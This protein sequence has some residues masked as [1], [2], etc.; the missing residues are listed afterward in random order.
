[1]TAAPAAVNLLIFTMEHDLAAKVA[2][3]N[4]M[5]PFLSY[6]IPE[7]MRGL[8]REGS[9]VRVP[10]RGGTAE[11]VVMAVGPAD[12]SK[13][14]LRH[15]A[16]LVQPQ[17][18]L[19]PDLLKLAVWM[20]DYYCAGLQSV[21][22]SMIPAAVRCGKGSMRLKE[23]SIARRLGED[24]MQRLE[25]R[26]P[27]QARLYG[28][29]LQN[30]GPMLR[31]ALLKMAGAAD[32]AAAA[33]IEK[34]VFAEAERTVERVSYE[35][36][37]GS[38]ERVASSPHELNSEQ[39]AA[40]GGILSAIGSKKFAAH[41]LY[42]VTG[43][44]KT[45]VYMQAMQRV[46]QDGGSCI[47]L[48][49]EISLTPQTVGR[50]RSRLGGLGTELVV[51]HSGLSDGQRLDAWRALAEG[52]A[53][54]VVGAR[55]CVFAPIENPDLIIV[56]EEHDGA[57]KQDKTPRYNG[58]DV[59]VYRAHLA[60]STCVLGSATPSLETLYNVRQKKYGMSRIASR[61]DGASLPKVV[62]ADMRHEKPGAMISN[63]LAS[64]LMEKMDRGE[65]AMLFL[66]RRGY[67]KVYEC[68]D[69]GAVEEC[70][71]CA[72]SLT[73]HKSENTVKCHLCG[74]QK[75][76]PACCPKCGSADAK[77]KSHGT[78]KIEEIVR[79][80]L[81]S[82][83]IGRMDADTMKRRDDYRRVLADFR[84]GALDILIGTQMI[85]KGLDF[86][87]VTL[88]GVVN[89]DISLHMPDFRAAEHT[90]QLIVQVAGR[91][92]RG[93]ARGE[94]IIQTR[95][96]EAAPIQYAKSDDM[97]SFLEEELA[98]RIEY[99]YPPSTRLVRH[100]FK[101]RS[102]QKLEFYTEEWAKLAE[103]E[104][105]GVCQIRGPV[106]AP[107]ERAEDFYRWQIWY[108]CQSASAVSSRIARMREAFKFDPEVQ[109]L[110][111]VDPYDLS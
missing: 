11:G 65:Q 43:S 36:D 18:V 49:P 22:E 40:L 66:N 25:R 104:L 91:A 21:L 90:Y 110:L 5:D 97:E 29:L 4:G 60:G 33:L 75:R 53:R 69:C 34:G 55:S 108:F 13:F 9:M 44:G 17:R 83:R 74:F 81:P 72:V 107:V 38:A 27:V 103:R 58:R 106:P 28:A 31:A 15:L 96:P 78:Q 2:L 86:P 63:L 57:Y 111:D 51:W 50:L 70:P 105:A 3:L 71:H 37:A 87:R 7:A 32:S 102:L 59:A 100:I 84:R 47:F 101:S 16:G 92:G 42:G 35:D 10:L 76:A 46:L 98:S 64:K 99:G 94:V 54:V 67:S 45:E 61:I 73:W 52:R 12:E 39:A 82:A 80:M 14:R 56:D 26:A 93:D 79:A 85:A 8:V 24:E 109:E 88:V 19:T 62:I 95:S 1:M 41:L 48:V 20:R 77:W 68:P 6:R 89:A 23:V 30:G